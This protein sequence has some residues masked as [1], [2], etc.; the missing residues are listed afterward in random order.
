MA[1]QALHSVLWPL[2]Q[3][4]VHM[5][6]YRADWFQ[7]DFEILQELFDSPHPSENIYAGFKWDVE[8][9]NF[10]SG[11]DLIASQA[12][13]PPLFAYALASCF[14]GPKMDVVDLPECFAAMEKLE[15]LKKALPQVTPRPPGS[16]RD[17]KRR[18]KRASHSSDEKASDEQEAMSNAPVPRRIIRWQSAG[19]E[20]SRSNLSQ[21]VTRKETDI[22]VGNSEQDNAAFA[23]AAVCGPSMG[24]IRVLS[25]QCLP[26]TGQ[27][28]Y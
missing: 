18:F 21:S 24:P 6:G 12:S 4:E 17:T 28:I 22:I 20:T 19:S 15:L 2:V 7:K 11:L 13:D 14:R 3:K 16:A 27:Y 26:D 8:L 9:D 1:R 25:A 23:L 5:D 10:W